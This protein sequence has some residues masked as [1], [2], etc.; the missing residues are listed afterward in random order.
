[1]PIA[2]EAFLQRLEER[3]AQGLYRQ[4]QER[5][6]QLNGQIDRQQLS[7]IGYDYLGLSQHPEVI[8]TL[9]QAA[10]TYGTSSSSSQL[11]GG[12]CSAHRE[13]EEALADFTGHQRAL[14]FSSGYMANLALGMALFT[15]KDQ[16]FHDKRNHVSLLDASRI[17]EAQLKR[18]RH[19]D[20]G[21][22]TQLLNQSPG[23]HWIC[24]DAVFSMEGDL[25]PLPELIQLSE[26][27]QAGLIIDDA[28]G[29]GVL[30]DH[31]A[32]IAEHFNCQGK[33]DIQ[34]VTFGK[35]LGTMGAAVLGSEILIETMLQFARTCIYTTALPPALAQATLASLTLLQEEAWRRD[36]LRQL[37]SNFQ[38]QA[39]QFNLPIL[40]SNTAIQCL[41]VKDPR[42]SLQ[43]AEQLKQQG[44]LVSA[45][46]PPTVA[47]NTSRLRINI[48]VHHSYQDIDRLIKTLAQLYHE[49]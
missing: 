31:G 11:L 48:T 25:A 9:Q 21:H 22:L 19:A 10:Q 13:L 24:S 30:G 45:I 1:M 35:A 38:M 27:F 43:F 47:P 41:I 29:F 33:M 16:V 4:R 15:K 6:S 3:Q 49:N 34:I 40:P 5:Q 42:R 23:P 32:G 7:F 44:I 39:R 28:H 46:R 2:E 14:I 18:Y 26:K 36:S 37:I 17:S 8:A 12:Y 20:I